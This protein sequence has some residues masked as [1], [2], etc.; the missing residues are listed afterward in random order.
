MQSAFVYGTVTIIFS[1]LAAT[2][3]TLFRDTLTYGHQTLMRNKCL[4]SPQL[5]TSGIPRVVCQTFSSW[6]KVP[7]HVH[8]QFSR[9]A[10]GFT[11]RFFDDA[12]AKEYIRSHYPEKVQ[13]AY[14]KLRGAHKADL[15]RYCYLYREGGVYLDI[16]TVLHASLEDVVSIVE[17][18]NCELATCLTEPV[19]LFPLRAQVYQGVLIARP[20]CVLF[21]E[22]IE[23]ATKYWWR[24][25]IDY[26]NFI[27][28]I[29]KRLLA[30][31]SNELNPGVSN[32]GKTY[33]FR[34][35]V[36]YLRC[37]GNFGLDMPLLTRSRRTFNCSIIASPDGNTLMGTRF[38]DYPWRQKKV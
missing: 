3:F 24:T 11:R 5:T 28:N 34:E 20:G 33:F 32:D 21:L 8:E 26:L 31:N 22:C 12:S 15:F 37:H 18:H 25:R 16:K 2:W 14:A 9:L 1:V 30:V 10:P 13:R 36:S 7:A 38:P 6:Q 35:R 29:S 27:R 17:K 4:D 23:Y 19:I